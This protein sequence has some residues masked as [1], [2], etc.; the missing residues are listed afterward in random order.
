[1]AASTTIWA[2]RPPERLVDS[3][4]L[5]GQ[6]HGSE[7]NVTKDFFKRVTADH[8]VFSGN[9]QHGN[10]ERATLEMLTEARGK[11]KYRILLTYPID[12]I[13]VAREA[14]WH[15]KKEATLGPWD[16]ACHSL[17]AFLADNPAVQKRIELVEEGVPHVI[18]LGAPRS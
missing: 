11:A 16:P 1:M 3:G 8:Y 18:D 2:S 14:D 9:G 10:P 13:D 5:K 12:E 4:V 17:T 7:N 15:Q 6:H